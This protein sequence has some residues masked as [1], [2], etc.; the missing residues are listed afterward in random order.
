[1][2][3]SN[4]IENTTE[5]W[6]IVEQYVQITPLKHVLSLIGP[7]VLNAIIKYYW[8]YHWTMIWMNGPVVAIYVIKTWPSHILL[9]SAISYLQDYVQH[10]AVSCIDKN[11]D[12]VK[13]CNPNMMIIVKFTLPRILYEVILTVCLLYIYRQVI[14]CMKGQFIPVKMRCHVGLWGEVV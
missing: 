9:V 3:F 12:N 2:L 5:V 10:C 13:Q 4:A 1:M 8:E 11:D 14:Q 7:I 6:V